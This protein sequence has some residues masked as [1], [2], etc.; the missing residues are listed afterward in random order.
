MATPSLGPTTSFVFHVNDFNAERLFV[1]SNS[2]ALPGGWNH[3]AITIGAGSI[4][5]YLNGSSIG[6]SSM[7]AYVLRPST[8]VLAGQF[9][10]ALR[11]SG[12]EA[13]LVFY[14][15]A[16][17]AA[18]VAQLAVPEPSAF[19][20]L[21][22]TA[23]LWSGAG[24][25]RRAAAR[26]LRAAV[27][28]L[29]LIAFAQPA[30]SLAA[31]SLVSGSAS[32]SVEFSF[33]PSNGVAPTGGGSGGNLLQLAPAPF[34]ANGSLGSSGWSTATW[35]LGLGGNPHLQASGTTVE[36]FQRVRRCARVLVREGTGRFH[37]GAAFGTGLQ[38]YGEQ[39]LGQCYRHLGGCGRAGIFARRRSCHQRA[40]LRGEHRE[41]SSARTAGSGFGFDITLAPASNVPTVEQVLKSL[42]LTP[43]IGQVHDKTGHTTLRKFITFD[44]TSS[45]HLPI[46][47]LAHLAGFDH[48]NFLSQ[49]VEVPDSWEIKDGD[50]VMKA[51]GSGSGLLAIGDP[52]PAGVVRTIT[53]TASGIGGHLHDYPRDTNASY[54]DDA[55]VASSV[56]MNAE[57]LQ[58]YDTPS[59]KKG[60]FAPSIDPL[61]GRYEEYEQFYTQLVGVDASG[62]HHRTT[63]RTRKG[64]ALLGNR[65]K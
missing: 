27:C 61:T 28:L 32:T 59:L 7:P 11:F 57:T 19:A 43:T 53:N 35:S 18:E 36:G 14:D 12:Y 9:E 26:S 65:T 23:G 30:V 8:P 52:P 34:P 48:F 60:M 33:S 40:F 51:A 16:L 38:L 37:R 46:G 1:T 20:L 22:L 44:L 4:A 50:T 58:F 39:D 54:L 63:G 6:E 2:V 42:S 17:S 25:P 47:D 56:Q 45:F 62:E 31:P 13:D 64:W 3:L 5:F 24:R 41:R 10:G 55:S 29:P 15:R 49:I 21:I